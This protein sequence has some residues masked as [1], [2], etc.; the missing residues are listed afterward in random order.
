MVKFKLFYQYYEF[1]LIS[2]TKK[3]LISTNNYK[4][5]GKKHKSAKTATLTVKRIKKLI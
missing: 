5:V 3:N 2:S 4:W 1:N